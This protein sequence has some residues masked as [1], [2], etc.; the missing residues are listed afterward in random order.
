MTKQQTTSSTQ[1]DTTTTAINDTKQQQRAI[2]LVCT[3][4]LQAAD[5]LGMEV[6]DE[7]SDEYPE[8]L[9]I[10]LDIKAS[11]ETAIQIHLDGDHARYNEYCQMEDVL[12]AALEGVR[13]AKEQALRS[14]QR[15]QQSHS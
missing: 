10:T 11:V 13:H 8:E 14:W 9:R 2:R 7:A 3:T 15:L 12:A 1:T 5:Y 6:Y 4:L